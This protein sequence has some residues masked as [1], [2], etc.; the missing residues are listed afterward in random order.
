M[1]NLAM[2]LGAGVAIVMIM[3][4][5]LPALLLLLPG[6]LLGWVAIKADAYEAPLS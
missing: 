2:N 4:W 5:G 3:G 1:K 6:A